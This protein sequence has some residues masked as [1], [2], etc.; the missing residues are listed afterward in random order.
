MMSVYYWAALIRVKYFSHDAYKVQVYT[1]T[2]IAT[3]YYFSA[4]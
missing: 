2:H 1:E 3:I 4:D